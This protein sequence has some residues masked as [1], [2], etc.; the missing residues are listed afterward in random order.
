ML[1]AGFCHRDVR[2]PNVACS[3]NRQQFFWLDLEMAAPLD[4]EAAAL[5]QLTGWPEGVLVG[6][7]YTAASELYMLGCLFD[8]AC[9]ANFQIS[10]AGRELLDC[11]KRPACQQLHSARQLL[12]HQWFAL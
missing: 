3:Y 6:G 7:K 2:W 4:S 1:Q 5:S 8:E 9:F 12:G 11:L 10:T